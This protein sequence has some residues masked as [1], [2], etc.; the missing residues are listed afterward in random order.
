[1]WSRGRSQ[2]YSKPVVPLV[3]PSVRFPST[4][5]NMG[6]VPPPAALTLP[7]AAAYSLVAKDLER[8]REEE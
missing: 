7:N 5:G 2:G 8:R 4:S 6:A 1:M 3:E